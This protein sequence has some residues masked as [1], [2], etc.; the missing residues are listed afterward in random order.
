[1][2]TRIV[3][4]DVPL[5]QTEEFRGA[6]L[7]AKVETEKEDGFHE[8]K[9]FVVNNNPTKFFAYERL[10]NEEVD[11]RHNEQ[12]YT[13]A[14]FDFIEKSGIKHIVTNIS[15]TKPVPDHSKLANPEDEVFVIFFI[16][17]F[18]PEYRERLLEQFEKHI[19]HTKK[20]PG[21]I[22][23]DLYTID[24]VEDE[25]VV[26]EHWRKESDVWDIHFHQPY[27]EVTGALMKEAIIGDMEQYMNFVTE[28]DG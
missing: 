14:L 7:E 21:N 24:G 12:A 17:K 28:V 2:I 18:K 26:Y 13:K 16:F 5:D 23:F 8:A 22:L 20:E 4:F 9:L 19:V 6:F 3:K 1:M 15:D 10:E 25:L 11:R 27:A